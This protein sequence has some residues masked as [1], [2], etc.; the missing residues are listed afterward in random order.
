MG[1][2]LVIQKKAVFLDRDGV[3]N[4]AI[5]KNGK[6]Y[7]PATF[8]EL[9]IS[10]GVHLA[11]DILKSANYL[12]IG[13]TNQ[14]DVAR[15]KTSQTLVEEINSSLISMLPIEEIFTCFHDDICQCKCRKPLPGM[16]LT[17][18][19]KYNIHLDTSFMIGDRGKDIQA[20]KA[21]GCKT[22]WLDYNYS[23]PRPAVLPDF[24]TYSLIQAARWIT[25]SN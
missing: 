10:E 20:G 4:E 1:K 13:I 14:P 22:I 12:I 5:I 11:L 3:I 9:T 24:V 17:A 23:E 7:P 19:Q 2:Y 16:L 18:A 15:K 8:E 6:P 25:N 21:A